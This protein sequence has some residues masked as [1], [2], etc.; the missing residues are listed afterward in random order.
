M[1]P[2]GNRT[3]WKQWDHSRVWH[4]FTQMKEWMAEDPL[5]MER[6][7]GNYVIDIDGNRYFDGSSSLW[8]NVHGHGRPEIINAICE[9]AQR[10]A[11]STMLGLSNLPA[12]E[13]AKKLTDIAP[14]GLQRV[15]YSDAGATA[16]EAALKMAFA[17][18]QLRGQPGRDLFVSLN[19]GYHGDTLGSLSVGYLELFDKPYRPLLF[20]CLKLNPPHIFRYYRRQSMEEA[21]QNAL[22]EAEQVLTKDR[23]RI[24]ALVVEPLMQA[25][26]VMWN[27]PVEYLAGLHRICRANNILMIADEVAVGFGRTGKMFACEHAGIS[28]DLMCLAKGLSG[29]TLPLSATLA[30]EEIFSA[31]LGEFEEGKAFFHGHTYCGNPIACAAA[32]ASLGLFDKDD[33]LAKLPASIEVLSVAL[34]PLRG[35]AHVADIR[36]WGFMVGI[37]LVEDVASRRPFP[38]AQRVGKK[39]IM[40]AR[41]RGVILRPLGDVVILMPPLSTTDDELRN[42][43]AVVAESIAALAPAR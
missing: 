43:V 34:E 19:E 5:F 7:E 10:L 22:A 4:P 11:H 13:L 37:E 20:P 6:G 24:A 31:F 18:W 38:A 14:A 30:T 41:K 8:C 26:A 12:T 35:L 16:V 40:E 27:H 9:Q 25:A 39:V 28:P 17:Y 33:V 2:T 3:P 23:R 1:N 32:L 29:G 15:F 36:Q 42:L 21:V